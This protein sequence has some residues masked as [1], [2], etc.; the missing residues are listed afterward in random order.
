MAKITL[1]KPTLG[2]LSQHLL[3]GSAMV[4]ALFP[5]LWIFSAAINPTGSLYSGS[6]IPPNW[7]FSN[8]QA[9]GSRTEG[10]FWRWTGNSFLVSSITSLL[11]VG[12]TSLS[13]YAFS[14][15][16]FAFRRQLLLLVLLVQ[17]FPPMLTMVALFLFIQIL[18]SYLPLFGLNTYGGL[19]LVYLGGQMGINIWFMK[20]FFDSIPREIDESAFVDGATHFQ[21]YRYL[22]LPLAKPILAV[23]AILVFIGTFGEF[24][25]ASIFMR[26]T[27]QY[28][29]MVGLY[30]F[31]S[32]PLAQRWGIFAAG[33]L[34]A[35]IPI[36]LVY[37]SLQDSIVNGLTQGAVKG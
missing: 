12:I 3:L 17:V 34:V 9:L 29:L 27:E 7:S 25:L 28:T 11:A 20:G 2:S 36:I 23:I 4:F 8:F 30:L 5:I 26:S 1:Q 16:R 18:G 14:R 33:S 21:T 10:L 32:D 15:F 6:L 35:S 24:I 19:I 13:A 31:I 22:I 37:L